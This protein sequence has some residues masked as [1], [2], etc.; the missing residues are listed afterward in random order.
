[1]SSFIRR[2]FTS[3]NKSHYDIVV[4]GG[5]MI[6]TA[7]A[8]LFGKFYFSIFM[9]NEGTLLPLPHFMNKKQINIQ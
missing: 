7:I 1:M 8:C 9:V 2:S 3:I 5:G 6:G 4:S